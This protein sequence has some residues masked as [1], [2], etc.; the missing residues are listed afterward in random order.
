MIKSEDESKIV[1]VFR[2]GSVTYKAIENLIE[3]GPLTTNEVR[4]LTGCYNSRIGNILCQ[5]PEIYFMG[6]MR[7]GV[8]Y[9]E[10]QVQEARERYCKLCK[11]SEKRKI[12]RRRN[13][14]INLPINTAIPSVLCVFKGVRDEHTAKDV[15]RNVGGNFIQVKSHLHALSKDGIL[16]VRGKKPK[17]YRINPEFTSMCGDA[18]RE[19]FEDYF[20]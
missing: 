10:Y 14:I 2:K 11:D 4:E 20:R 7:C 6:S 13:Q 15:W 5:S 8:W 17:V 9:L 3:K 18:A 12:E 1:R 19:I 16:R